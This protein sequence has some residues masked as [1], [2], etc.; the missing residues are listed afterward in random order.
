MGKRLF[1]RI[2][3]I[4]ILTC[5]LLFIGAGFVLAQG[6]WGPAADCDQYCS[7]PCDPAVGG[8]DPPAGS[9]CICNP[10]R[11]T[12]VEGLI[13][14]V[15]NFIFYIATAITPVL[16]LYGAFTFITSGGEVDK[17][18]KAKKIIWYTIIGYAIVLFSRGL[19]S[20][21]EQALGVV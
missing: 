20:L 19:A 14:N 17:V 11:A 8:W 4:V 16:V 9:L 2:C 3:L 12:T 7:D 13:E 15:I 6:C 1:S 18:N 10:W 5:A 21:L